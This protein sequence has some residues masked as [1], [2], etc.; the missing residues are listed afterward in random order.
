MTDAAAWAR[1]VQEV[2]STNLETIPPDGN[3]DEL[4]PI[5]AQD[6]VAIVATDDQYFGLITR[7]DLLNFLQRNN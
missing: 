5:F 4:L 7:I 3:T 6:R 1:P 2:M